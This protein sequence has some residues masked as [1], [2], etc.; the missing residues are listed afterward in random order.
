VADRADQE[1]HAAARHPSSPTSVEKTRRLFVIGRED[2]RIV[3]VRQP[4]S[5]PLK[6]SLQTDPR[7]NLLT[8]RTN[9]AGPAIADQR[10]PLFYNP[11]LCEI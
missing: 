7:E 6:V 2:S 1:V 9:E 11:C 8:D 10:S 5:E 3:E 4:F